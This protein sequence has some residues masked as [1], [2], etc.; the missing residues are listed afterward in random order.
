MATRAQ[1]EAGLIAADRAGNT[2]D[3]KAFA[4][5]IRA[6]PAEVVEEQVV[7]EGPAVA[8]QAQ[9][10]QLQGPSAGLLSGQP[11]GGVP[12]PRVITDTALEGGGATIGQIAGAPFAPATGGLSIP[13]GGS[14]G[15]LI[16]NYG[17]QKARISSGEQDKVNIGELIGA[18]ITGAVPGST[19]AKSGIKTIAKEAAKQG[20]AGLARNVVQTGIDEGDIP[21]LESA[22]LSTLIPAAGGALARRSDLADP[23]IQSSILAAERNVPV[24]AA[25]LAAAQKEGYIIP[26]SQVNPS[27]LNSRLESVAGKAA[28]SQSASVKNQEITNKLA[29]RA[30]GIPEDTQ[31]TESVLRKVRDESAKPYRE[32]EE[33]SNAAREKISA[34]QKERFTA[35]DP[36]ELAI[37][38]ADPKTLAELA[39]LE[40]QA[41]ANITDLRQARN[42]AHSAYNLYLRNAD[43]DALKTA[44]DAEALADKLEDAIEQAAISAGKSSLVDDLIAARQR[45][46][47]SY[48]VEKAINLGN[49]DVSAP[50]I[51]R[52][53]DRGRPL[54]GELETIGRFQQAYP[55][56]AR[57]AASVPTPGVSKVEAGMAALLAATGAGATGSGYGA[58]AGALPLLSG[59]ARS[60]VLSH[61]YQRMFAQF[62]TPQFPSSIATQ[63]AIAQ[64]LLAQ[65][66]GASAA[67]NN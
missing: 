17:A 45:I 18:A 24:E 29:N 12:V 50:V 39:P 52:L 27:A 36:F 33:L 20:A 67:D 34:I 6:L 35:D 5:A 2:E 63:E 7:V 49:A 40:V 26:P 1:L 38:K 10:S 4:A 14:I 3:A 15:G 41:A 58:L 32:I 61:P 64:R 16:G 53:L 51:G 22:A 11:R 43:P 13:V 47:R 19:V 44:R 8:T 21:T 66:A 60:A 65:S 55:F 59:P 23:K 62:P 9:L 46:A 25:T 48:D 54:T 56:A 37:Q 28:V 30:L 31:I 57:E 42:D